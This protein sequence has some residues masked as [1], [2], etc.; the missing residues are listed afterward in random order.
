[1]RSVLRKKGGSWGL[2][3][4]IGFAPGIASDLFSELVLCLMIEREP[5]KVRT[6]GNPR[7]LRG[8]CTSLER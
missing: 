8:T 5:E 4:P 1:M 6:G 2:F 7:I 3:A